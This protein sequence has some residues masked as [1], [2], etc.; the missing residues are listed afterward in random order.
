MG[1]ISECLYEILP[2][3]VYSTEHYGSGDFRKSRYGT[4]G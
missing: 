1:R 2:E 4:V 3:E